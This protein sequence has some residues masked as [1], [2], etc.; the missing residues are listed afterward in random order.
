MV[1]SECV[2]GNNYTI[3]TR[4]KQVLQVI[5]IRKFG[6]FITATTWT[7]KRK[8]ACIIIKIMIKIVLLVAT[9]VAVSE[10]KLKK[11]M[12]TFFFLV[13]TSSLAGVFVT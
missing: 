2:Y 3:S 11:L 10:K 1:I 6:E 13:F 4:I 12:T 8:S 7:N 5:Q 9:L